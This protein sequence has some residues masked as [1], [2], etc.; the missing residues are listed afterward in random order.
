MHS[1]AWDGGTKNDYTAVCL[2]TG[3]VVAMPHSMNNPREYGGTDGDYKVTVRAGFAVVE[4]SYFCG[5]DVGCT[6]YLAAAPVL[7]GTEALAL[8]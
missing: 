3:E 6:V 5:R 1:M 8:P 4:H 2:T 7:T